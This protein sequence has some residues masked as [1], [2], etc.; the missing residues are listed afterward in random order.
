MS[1]EPDAVE[2]WLV[3]QCRATPSL[4]ALVDDRI[5]LGLAPTG[6][7]LPYVRIQPLSA[8]DAYCIPLQR[9]GVD[10]E[11]GLYGVVAG[12]DYGLLAALCAALEAAFPTPLEALAGSF[13]LSS[14]RFS[15]EPLLQD[16]Q[17]GQL[18]SQRGMRLRIELEV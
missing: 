15:P 2:Q 3:A 10:L 12:A 14:Y 6:L 9:I 18:Y 7:P 17:A 4:A 1:W 13:R 8:L 16:V 11:Y 5:V